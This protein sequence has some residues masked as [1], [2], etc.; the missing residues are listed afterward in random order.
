MNKGINHWESRWDVRVGWR[1][2]GSRKELEALWIGR[3]REQDVATSVS[4]FMVHL[5]EFATGGF[6]FHMMYM[7][8]ILVFVP[9]Y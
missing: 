1:K 3:A 5:S 7:I 8:R 9:R 6:R 4:W 2:R